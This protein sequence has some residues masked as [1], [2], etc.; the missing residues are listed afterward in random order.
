MLKLIKKLLFI[1]DND[2]NDNNKQPDRT[3]EPVTDFINN[4]VHFDNTIKEQPI[5]S[6]EEFDT[7]IK[8]VQETKKPLTDRI[9][10]A[11]VVKYLD[12]KTV[13]KQKKLREE[14]N[15]LREEY[16]KEGKTMPLFQLV[17][18]GPSCWNGGFPVCG[19]EYDVCWYCGSRHL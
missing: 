9:E 15:K 2:N 12:H 4:L 18:Y 1:D 10:R 16:N 11:K 6:E 5:I 8:K 13:V 19:I 3:G 7:L 14:Y 17:A